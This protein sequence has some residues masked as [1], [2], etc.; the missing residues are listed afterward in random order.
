MVEVLDCYH[1][2]YAR[3]LWLLAW[4]EK[5]NNDD[6][7]RTGFCKRTDLAARLGVSPARVSQI[8]RELEG[9]GVI[10]RLGGGVWGKATE[11]E[12]LPLPAGTGAQG[13]PRADPT[14]GKPRADP[15]GDAQGKPR[16]NAQ[17]KPR[18]NAQGKP[19]AYPIPQYPQEPSSLSAREDDPLAELA[20]LGAT[21]REIETIRIKIRN[22]PGVRHPGAY[23]RSAIDN[24]DG[25]ELIRQARPEPRPGDIAAW[26]P[27]PPARSPKPPWC[28][29][30]D[31]RTRQIELP[32]ARVAR[33]PC[34]H[35][36]GTN[37]DER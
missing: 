13:K 27:G 34:C 33:C 6:G 24:G 28:G 14:Q 25:P 5:V 30:C 15:T 7:S 32:D 16:A 8:A 3:K 29:Q 12:L 31:E 20:R 22:D 18:A 9:E 36:L 10:K 37:D 11:Y 4:A 1:G 23:L 21:E 2:P 26:D 17:G 19:R 35:P